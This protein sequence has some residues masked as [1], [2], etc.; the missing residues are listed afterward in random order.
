MY[1]YDKMSYEKT[2]CYSETGAKNNQSNQ[3]CKIFVTTNRF[4]NDALANIEKHKT[5]CCAYLHSLTRNEYTRTCQNNANVFM[6]ISRSAKSVLSEIKVYVD[7]AT[8]NM[9]VIL[10]DHF[11]TYI[12]QYSIRQYLYYTFTKNKSFVQNVYEI[13]NVPYI[14][15]CFENL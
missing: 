12:V 15:K 5:F 2:M 8:H 3:L 10:F 14:P 11:V 13:Y 7:R 9:K 6:K 1:V 4:V